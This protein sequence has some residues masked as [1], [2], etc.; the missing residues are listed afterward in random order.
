MK[1]DKST[2]EEVVLFQSREILKLQLFSVTSVPGA[3][4]NQNHSSRNSIRNIR[5]IY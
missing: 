1:F 2:H 5:I 3:V 4:N